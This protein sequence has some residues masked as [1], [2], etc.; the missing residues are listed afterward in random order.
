[1]NKQEIIDEAVHIL[2]NG[3]FPK[4]SEFLHAKFAEQEK[5]FDRW[6]VV[7]DFPEALYFVSPKESLS[8]GIAGNGA[9]YSDIN[10]EIEEYYRLATDKEIVEKLSA[11]ATSIGIM[12]GATIINSNGY[13]YVLSNNKEGFVYRGNVNTLYFNSYQVMQ[14]G[15]WTTVVANK[16]PKDVISAS[17]E[18]I[19]VTIELDEYH[20]Q[21]GDGC[22][23]DYGTVTKVNGKELECHNQDVGTIIEGILTELGYNVE[24]I[25]TYN[26]E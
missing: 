21:C 16:P 26:G 1:M 19:K 11:H 15:K 6:Y 22:C 14:D 24:I 18:H 2:F 5:P 17:E 23:T 8:Y 20:T 9:W 7:D 13:N 25:E 3:G 4:S 12:A 10:D